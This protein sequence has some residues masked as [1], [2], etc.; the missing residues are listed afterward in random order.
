[1]YFLIG[2]QQ[3]RVIS[4]RLLLMIGNAIMPTTILGELHHH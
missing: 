1:M 4:I 3:R 2:I